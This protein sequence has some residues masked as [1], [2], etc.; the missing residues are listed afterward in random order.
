MWGISTLV[1][2]SSTSM[3]VVWQKVQYETAAHRHEVNAREHDQLSSNLETEKSEFQ[4]NARRNNLLPLALKLKL[5]DIPTDGIVLLSFQDGEGGPVNP[6]LDGLVG[7]AQAS[8]PPASGR[9]T[10]PQTG[11]RDGQ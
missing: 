2:L 10:T 7:V 5:V 1:V 9:S 6:M 3:S 4:K 8:N 11:L